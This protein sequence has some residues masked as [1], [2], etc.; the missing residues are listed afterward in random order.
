FSFLKGARRAPLTPRAR[1]GDNVVRKL[2]EAAE[3]LGGTTSP[4]ALFHWLSLLRLR[5]NSGRLALL[6]IYF[7]P[8]VG[9][10]FAVDRLQGC[11]R[12]QD[13]GVPLGLEIAVDVLERHPLERRRIGH[14]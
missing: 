14:A 10:G 9:R 6:A 2:H 8:E 4:A 7:L 3:L 12:A 13:L 1:V 5:R 11:Q